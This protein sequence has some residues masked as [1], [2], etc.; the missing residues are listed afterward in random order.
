M[1][2][3]DDRGE[4]VKKDDRTLMS[5]QHHIPSISF[6]KWIWESRE[7]RQLLTVSGTVI[8]IQFIIFK[9]LYPFPNFLPDSYSYME[10]AFN[11]QFIN[12]WPIGYSKFLRLF[13]VFTK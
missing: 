3:G 1:E 12:M 9:Y 5:F 13:S 2:S 4:I 7:G 11:N 6:R 10:A 8:L